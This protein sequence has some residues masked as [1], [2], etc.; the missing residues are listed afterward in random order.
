[1]K[2][3]VRL[4]AQILSPSLRAEREALKGPRRKRAEKKKGRARSPERADWKKGREEEEP[5]EKP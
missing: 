2:L 1:M 5:S 3:S 4:N